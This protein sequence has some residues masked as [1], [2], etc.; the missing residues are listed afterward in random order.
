MSDSRIFEWDDTKAAS[1]LAKHGIAFDEAIRV[2]RDPAYVDVDV[3]RLQ[4]RESRRKA[5]GAIQGR[6][7]TVVYTV[8]SDATRL[9]SARRCN[10][11]ERSL[12]GSNN[13]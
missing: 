9:I 2:F 6:L 8:R 7:F 5:I 13:S 10:S 4:D 3:S 12:Y 1:N 11:P